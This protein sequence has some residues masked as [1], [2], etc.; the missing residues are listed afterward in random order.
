M[1]MSTVMNNLSKLYRLV[2][3]CIGFHLIDTDGRYY[4][5][6]ND[7]LKEVE[8]CIFAGWYEYVIMI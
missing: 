7:K 6:N 2:S 3:P 4:N 8:A 1:K 5:L